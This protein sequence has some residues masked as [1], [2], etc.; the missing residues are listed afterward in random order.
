LKRHRLAYLLCSFSLRCASVQAQNLIQNPDFDSDFTAWNTPFSGN[1]IDNADGSPSAPSAQ[2]STVRFGDGSGLSFV[3][4]CV[5]L[6]GFPPPWTFGARVRVV[7]STGTSCQI[8]VYASFDTG[9]CAARAINS[10]IGALASGTVSGTQGDF[11]QY[12]ITISDPMPAGSPSHAADLIIEASCPTSGDSMT[13]NFDHA[14]LG[15][16]GT[17][18][19]RL[20]SFYVE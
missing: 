3:D 11:T 14:Y 15:T 2:F 8:Y 1:T 6:I 10:G 5:S 7:S 13:I 19:V 12:A 18:P 17:T 4:Q 20:Q 16:S 9:T